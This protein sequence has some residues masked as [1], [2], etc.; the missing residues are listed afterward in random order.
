M[1]YV[2]ITGVVVGSIVL[3]SLL[4]LFVTGRIG[5]RTQRT[6]H[7]VIN[8]N[9]IP[10]PAQVMPMQAIT[11][12]GP[13]DNG[14]VDHVRLTMYGFSVD[15]LYSCDFANGTAAHPTMVQNREALCTFQARGCTLEQGCVPGA[16]TGYGPSTFQLRAMSTQDWTRTGHG[17]RLQIS[18]TRNGTTLESAKW[19]LSDGG[20][21]EFGGALPALGPGCGAGAS[22]EG[23][24]NA[25]RV[26]VG[27]EPAAACQVVFN[28]AWV[29]AYSRAPYAPVCTVNNETSAE[30]VRATDVESTG[31]RLA[32][33]LQPND[34]VSVVCVGRHDLP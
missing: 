6:T 5:V 9:T 2:R 17:T 8:K 32:G 31:L 12:L 23:S 15:P 26:V 18:T 1:R 30:I 4:T 24:D 22:I 29:L 25:F 7:L 16:G 14:H 33:R 3:G 34:R 10:D 27:R 20:H 11:I 21:M 28:N 19:N 13:D